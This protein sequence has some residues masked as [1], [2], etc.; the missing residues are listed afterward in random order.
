L[1]L[2]AL[3]YLQVLADY[4]VPAA[5]IAVQSMTNP[6]NISYNGERYDPQSY[7]WVGTYEIDY[8]APMRVAR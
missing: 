8:R 4:Q 3:W 7:W 2:Y 5:T 6:K 1:L